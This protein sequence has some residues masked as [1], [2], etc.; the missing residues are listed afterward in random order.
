MGIFEAFSSEVK[1]SNGLYGNRTYTLVIERDYGHLNY[2]FAIILI[3]LSLVSTLFNPVIFYYHRKLH[4]I[5]ALIF[6]ML[7]VS[8]FVT[9]IGFPIVVMYNLLNPIIYDVVMPASVLEQLYTIYYI[10][11]VATSNVLVSLLCITRY[12]C[13]RNSFYNIKRNLLI[14]YIIFY[15]LVV[16]GIACY[17][18]FS[19]DT[20]MW[21]SA[22][23]YVC[24]LTT[25]EFILSLFLAGYFFLH[26]IIAAITSFCTVYLLCKA[27]QSPG[28]S[29]DKHF[30]GSMTILMMSFMNFIYPTFSITY[31]CL[32]YSKQLSWFTDR[33]LLFISTPVIPFAMSALNPVIVVICS[34]G[35]KTMLKTRIHRLRNKYV[36]AVSLRGIF[37][38]ATSGRNKDNF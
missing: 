1:T 25:V 12:I 4:S 16:F 27:K 8:D 23:Q 7:S 31:T 21:C 5:S 28:I 32:A 19:T 30:K 18:T 35:I 9:N 17:M 3:M 13:I 2:F 14:A 34:S 36:A 22:T 11:A 24:P 26:F 37:I 6:T 20:P 10:T 29:H 15:I 38:N 33:L